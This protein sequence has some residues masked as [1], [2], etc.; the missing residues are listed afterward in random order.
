MMKL[1][2]IYVKCLGICLLCI[3]LMSGYTH[4][5][6]TLHY[7][8]FG[9][10]EVDE[11]TDITPLDKSLDFSVTPNPTTTKEVKVNITGA[12]LNH[13]LEITVYN[14]IGNVVYRTLLK[15]VTN[16]MAF[17]ITPKEELKQGLYF[18]TLKNG[19]ERVT[20]KFIVK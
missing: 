10:I 4:A 15:S 9:M 8:E 19:A 7:D 11:S 18:L 17:V 1:H 3:T 13:F 2:S 12:N 6:S 16:N 14:S 20:K 5:S